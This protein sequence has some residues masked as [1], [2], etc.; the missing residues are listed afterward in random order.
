ML[1][2]RNTQG[3]PRIDLGVTQDDLVRYIS[4]PLSSEKKAM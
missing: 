3:D 4:L 1:D 2:G